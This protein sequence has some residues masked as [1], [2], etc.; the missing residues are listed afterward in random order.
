MS[1]KILVGIGFIIIS[2]IT[3]FS[4]IRN[5]YRTINSEGWL[6]VSGKI[7]K[8]SVVVNLEKQNYRTSGGVSQIIYISIL[9][10]TTHG[11]F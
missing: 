11:N 3:L 10:E 7:I 5:L 9:I 6:E 4:L 8:T 1:P 2:G